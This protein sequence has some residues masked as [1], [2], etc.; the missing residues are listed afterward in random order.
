M[1]KLFNLLH[2]TYEEIREVYQPN[3]RLY[4]IADPVGVNGWTIDRLFLNP[5][6][7]TEGAKKDRASTGIEATDKTAQE[8]TNSNPKTTLPKT[9]SLIKSKINIIV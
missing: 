3:N 2:G 9:L 5:G 6:D 7:A 8:A 4:K 1:E